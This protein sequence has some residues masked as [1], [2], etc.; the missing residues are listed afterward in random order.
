MEP[1]ARACRCRPERVSI[2]YAQ[3]HILSVLSVLTAPA[4]HSTLVHSFNTQ[5]CSRVGPG[6]NKKN[7]G[8]GLGLDG[9][10]RLRLWL[11]T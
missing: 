3:S 7:T 11:G 9:Q 2:S 10:V 1:T 5:Q 8:L 6:N 4:L